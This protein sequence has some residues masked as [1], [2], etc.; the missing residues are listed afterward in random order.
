MSS[1]TPTAEPTSQQR[2]AGSGRAET[3]VRAVLAA[4]AAAAAVS[5]PPK[6][7]PAGPK[8]FPAAPKAA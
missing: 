1:T 3:P 8:P 7:L 6:P 5:T 4:C 2:A